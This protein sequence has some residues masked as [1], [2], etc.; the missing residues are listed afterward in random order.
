MSQHDHTVFD[1]TCPG[2][3]P[4]IL[5]TATGTPFPPQHEVSLAA[6]QC[7]DELNRKDQEALHRIWVLNSRTEADLTVAKRFT[8]A[9]QRRMVN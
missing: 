1:P 6:N 4:V 7:F 2:C 8:V 5:D 9:L 3:R